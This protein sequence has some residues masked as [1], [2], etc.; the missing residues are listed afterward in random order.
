MQIGKKKGK[1]EANLQLQNLFFLLQNRNSIC[2]FSHSS[3][4]PFDTHTHTHTRT[5]SF[6]FNFLYAAQHVR[7]FQMCAHYF[8]FYVCCFFFQRCDH[9]S[10]R[11][12][13]STM[14]LPIDRSTD[15]HFAEITQKT[16]AQTRRD[17]EGKSE[18]EIETERERK[19][20]RVPAKYT[21]EGL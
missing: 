5:Q 2:V 1:E 21:L 17:G 19:M 20:C 11:F 15:I 14:N 6:Q 4:F 9:F 3:L 16:H 10:H 8:Y 18:L 7:P 12:I 13:S